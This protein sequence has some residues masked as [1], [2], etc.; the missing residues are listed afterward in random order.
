MRAWANTTIWRLRFPSLAVLGL[1]TKRPLFYLRVGVRE[2]STPS[3][4]QS[5]GGF[6]GGVDLLGVGSYSSENEM[7]GRDAL[8]RDGYFRST[9]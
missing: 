3:K 8:A 7:G 1:P 5:I 4:L 9:P 2:F 6:P